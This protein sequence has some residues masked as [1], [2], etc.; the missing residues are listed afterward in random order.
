MD[1]LGTNKL[2][3]CSQTKSRAWTQRNCGLARGYALGDL[4]MC[5][6]FVKYHTGGVDLSLL[7]P[8]ILLLIA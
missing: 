8:V 5:F 3:Y 7:S 6:Q 1:A 2:L 4:R